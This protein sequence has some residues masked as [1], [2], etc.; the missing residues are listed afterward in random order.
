[1]IRTRIILALATLVLLSACLGNSNNPNP[2]TSGSPVVTGPNEETPVQPQAGD[3]VHILSNRA[4][5]ISDG[6]ALIEVTAQNPEMLKKVTVLLGTR[7]VSDQ[8]ALR[9]NGRYMG[10]LQGL[11][12]GENQLAVTLANGA[13][14]AKTVVNHPNGGPVFSGPQ[15]QPW[16]CTNEAATDAQCNQPVEYSFQ[17]LPANKLQH[18]L[19]RSSLPDQQFAP[20]FLPYDPQNPPPAGEIAMTTTDHGVTVPFI[21]R[22]ER[23]VQNRDRYQIRTLFNPAQAWQAW[24]PQP[25]WNGKV[26]IHHGGNVGVTYGPGNPPNGDISGT[27]P[28]GA[29]FL[30]GDSITVALGRGFVT[31]STALANLGHNVNL[32]TSAESLMMVKERIVE[33]YGEIRYTIGTG[34]S[35]GAI[36]QQH[37]ANAYPGIYQGLIVQ[38]S[39]PDV[40]TTATQF[41]D[42]NLLNSYFGNRYPGVNEASNSRQFPQF[43]PNVLPVVQW[44]VVYGHLPINPVL[45]DNAFFPKAYPYA[46]NCRGLNGAATPYDPVNNPGGLRCGLIDYM[47]TQFGLRDPAVWSANEKKI[48][49]GFGGIPLDNVGVQY[50]LGALKQGTL[51]PDQFLDLNRNIGGFDVDIQRIASRTVADPLALRN[52]Y[53]TGAVNTAEHLSDVPIIDLRGPDPGIA[54]DAFHSWQMRARLKATQGHFDNHVIWFGQ[55]VLAGDSTYSTEAL[56]VMDRWLGQIEADNTNA[57]LPQKVLANKPRAARDKCLSAQSIYAEDGPFVPLSGGLFYPDPVLP[58]A[59]STSIPKPPPEAGQIFDQLSMQFCGLD[60]AAADSTGAANTAVAPLTRAQQTVVQTRFG[61]PRT[62]AGDDIRT[63]VNKCVLKP[64]VAADYA[65]IPAISNPESFAAQVR[66]IFPEGVCDYTKPGVGTQPTQTWLAYGSATEKIV[67]GQRL[68]TRPANSQQG[69]FSPAF[70]R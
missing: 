39:Y 32:V 29:E 10:L 40:W 34:C 30:L 61:T 18:V 35:G 5:L 28:D 17:Y 62:V 57:P 6:N 15:V 63:L 3:A 12:L 24:Q 38:C 69:W 16:T 22:T 36:A 55:L 68:P 51:T 56:L 52:S 19:T 14:L 48:G 43:A 66:E 44:S 46:Q 13:R 60:L 42:Y 8:F 23:G 2:D 37:V 65:G 70:R 58:R 11:A 49:R 64:A 1:M 50:G 31:T 59:N 45:S 4:D 47:S 25:Q 21:I 67:G 9:A 20:T 33:Q 54:H 26:L 27:A 53:K 7:D 41:A